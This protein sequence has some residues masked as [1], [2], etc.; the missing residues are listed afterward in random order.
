MRSFY[1]RDY[2][3]LWGE[4]Y[5]PA[6]SAAQA[7]AIWTVLG[8]A[9]GSRVLDAP[10]G[11]GRLS[12]PLAER[13]AIVVGID[14]SEALLA[15][16]ERAHAGLGI[17]FVQHDLRAPIDP[18]LG[19]GTF[20]AAVNVF[21]S[22]GHNSEDDDRAMFAHT[23]AMLARG[24]RFLVETMHRDVIVARRA[25]GPVTNERTLAD[26][27][28]LVEDAQWDP[29]RGRVDS[30]WRWSGPDG[31]GE[32]RSS[33]R[34]YALP[35]LVRLL[36]EAGLDVTAAYRGCTTEPFTGL[37]PTA[38]GRCALVAIKR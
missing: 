33:L 8:L 11:F 37:G 13:G 14:Q 35:E 25:A 4:F 22:I 19:A 20:D 29:L 2:L 27:T 23:A 32:K 7:D 34:V 31:D 5:D 17:A 16:A 38:G 24:G 9:R 10:C 21:S 18:A 15:E 3:K 28:R 6:A 12:R 30:V 36:A 26:G 1:D